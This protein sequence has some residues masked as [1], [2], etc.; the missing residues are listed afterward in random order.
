MVGLYDTIF[1]EILS[2][3]PEKQKEL[4]Y[5]I[6]KEGSAR[7]IQSGDFIK[8]YSLTSSSSVQSAVKKLLERDLIVEQ[9]RVYSLSDKLFEMWIND[10]ID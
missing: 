9:N 1:R 3:I 10:V 5:A 8:K 6:A 4:L 7:Q 2:N